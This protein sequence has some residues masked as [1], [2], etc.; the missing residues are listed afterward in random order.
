MT[1]PRWAYDNLKPG[2]NKPNPIVQIIAAII[3]VLI[4]LKL[5][6]II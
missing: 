3:G 2:D 1:A 6:G 4:L 5:L